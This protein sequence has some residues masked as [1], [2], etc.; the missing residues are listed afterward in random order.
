MNHT[1]DLGSRVV[2]R[3]TSADTLRL[4]R[5]LG[6]VHIDAWAP[7]E[8]QAAT[9]PRNGATYDREKPL[10]PRY[11]FADARE[12]DELHRIMLNPG[13]RHPRF[14]FLMHMGGAALVTE[15]ALAGLREAEAEQ[16]AA[17]V[18]AKREGVK[19][20]Q[21]ELESEVKFAEGPLAGITGE[22][23]DQHGE[24][25]LVDYKGAAGKLGSIPI[26]IS[27]W[28]LLPDVAQDDLPREIAA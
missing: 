13:K 10:L 11:V 8:K 25:A 7:V 12:I 14:S 19:P 24:F 2:L 22:V 23:V 27:S 16:D 20:P 26:K 15:Q 18:K 28:I 9:M 4:V 6:S 1:L 5:S 3:T 21:V 17:Y